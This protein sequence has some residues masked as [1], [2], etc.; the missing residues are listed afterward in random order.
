M[1]YAVVNS[2]RR[3]ANMQD[4]NNLKVWKKAH[5][6]T[7]TVYQETGSFPK[8]EVYGLASQIRRAAASGPANIA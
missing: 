1:L 8:E 5:Q 6:L 2:K 3:I 4:F 7:L